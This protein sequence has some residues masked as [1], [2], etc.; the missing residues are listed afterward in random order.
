VVAGLVDQQRE[1]RTLRE[2]CGELGDLL[3]QRIEE[4][5]TLREQ[6]TETGAKLE[7]VRA[8]LHRS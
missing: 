5:K 4:Q 7:E 6:R 1:M 8:D 3:G 2:V